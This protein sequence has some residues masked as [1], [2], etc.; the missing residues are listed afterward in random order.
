MKYLDWTSRFFTTTKGQIL[1]LLRRPPKTVNDLADAL[2]ITDNAVRAQLATLE[3]DGLVQRT[4]YA[5]VPP[6]VEY[7]LTPLGR[8]L[9][10]LLATIREWSNNNVGE[11]IASQQQY[12]A[13]TSSRK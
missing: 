4:V 1:R 5:E 8:S 7:S 3:R 13:Q 12:D 10:E 2:E 9:Y 6:R 11:I